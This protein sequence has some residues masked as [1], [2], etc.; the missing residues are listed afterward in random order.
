MA[1]E[2]CIVTG[3]S[4]GLG[5]ALAEVLCEKG[6]AVWVTA[7]RGAELRALQRGCK[8]LKGRMEVLAGDLMNA[9]FRERL[10]RTVLRK[11]GQIDFLFN[12]A[13]FGKAVRFEEQTSEDIAGMFE[14]NAV[15]CQ[16]LS[17]LA[18]PAMLKRGKGRLIHTGS[19]VAFTP[20]AY[21]TTYNATKASVYTFNRSLTY[22]LRDSPVTSTV[23]LP[24]R[25]N[26]GFASSAY[27]TKGSVKEFNSSGEV[28]RKIAEWIVKRM[29]TG[30]EVITPGFR[31]WLLYTM[32]Y[33]GFLVDFVAKKVM[34][35]KAE[36]DLVSSG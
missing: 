29:N 24:S 33:F 27:V 16:H 4:S 2:V 5:K 14:V 9:P 22:E 30:Q 12:N 1:K 11:E 26:T 18:L 21:F 31:P 15:A 20:L 35:P 7:R 23:V 17:A 28:P 8:N 25:M 19:V 36:R 3:A 32:R 34:A 13:G 6:Y 10:I